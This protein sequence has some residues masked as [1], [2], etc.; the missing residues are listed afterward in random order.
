MSLCDLSCQNN[1]QTYLSPIMSRS[2]F[3]TFWIL[4]M[5]TWTRD[6]RKRIMMLKKC[7]PAL[8][9]SFPSSHSLSQWKLE[10]ISAQIEPLLQSENFYIGEFQSQ[11]HPCSGLSK[12]RFLFWGGASWSMK[13]HCFTVEF[14]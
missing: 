5:V 2:S 1:C 13:K 12:P 6:R 11:G 7:E 14:Y 10:K 8:Q 4:A 3:P 9:V